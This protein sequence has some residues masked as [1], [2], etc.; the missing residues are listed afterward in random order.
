LTIA[1]VFMGI[2]EL[3]FCCTVLAVG[4][5]GMKFDI[6][7][8]RTLAFVV[9]VFG[10]QATTYAIRERRRLWSSRPSFWLAMSSVADISIASTLAIGG[11]F[12][13]SLPAIVVA[14]ALVAA[15]VFAF[16]VDAAKV[17]VFGRL[18]IA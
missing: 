11:L 14:G 8:L 15:V 2:A 5:L 1:G 16:V 6:G 10:N 17:P 9:I 18:G 13:T 3:V 12:M 7:A 4:E